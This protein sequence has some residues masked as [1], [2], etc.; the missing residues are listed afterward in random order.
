LLFFSFRNYTT[1]RKKYNGFK[2]LH[3]ASAEK[4][5]NC[6][7]SWFCFVFS[8]SDV[9]IYRSDFLLI[10]EVFRGKTQLCGSEKKVSDPV[11][12]PD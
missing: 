11:S 10:L 6:D 9:D 2:T 8:L 5:T 3:G 12:D 1:E 4:K 7:A